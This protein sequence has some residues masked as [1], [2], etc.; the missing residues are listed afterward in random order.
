[1]GQRWEPWW[2]QSWEAGANA[3]TTTAKTNLDQFSHIL[4]PTWPTFMAGEEYVAQG[5][6]KVSKV[7]ELRQYIDFFDDATSQLPEKGDDLL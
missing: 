4:W 6:L 2:E 7:L 3:D 5:D 1:M